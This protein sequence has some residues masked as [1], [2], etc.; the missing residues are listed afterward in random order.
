MQ[1]GGESIEKKKEFE[2]SVHVIGFKS[3][4]VP[5]RSIIFLLRRSTVSVAFNIVTSNS[6]N[7]T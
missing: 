2:L 4:S 5:L 1:N 3:V 7:I 6:V